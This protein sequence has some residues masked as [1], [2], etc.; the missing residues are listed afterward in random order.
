MANTKRI[1]NYLL[2][3][4]LLSIIFHIL[5]ISEVHQWGDFALYLLQ[6]KSITE[7]SMEG[8][9]AVNT[10]SVNN[11][12]VPTGPNLYPWGFPL[13]LAPVY[14]TF[15]FNIYVFKIYL[16][17]IF[18]LILI[19]M[20]FLFKKKLGDLTSLLLVGIFAFNPL[21]IS[22]NNLI[23][24]DLP[25][26]LFCLLTIL[27]M[28]RTILERHSQ[29]VSY[30]DG[31]LLGFLI[32]FSYFIRSNGIVF[33]PILLVCQLITRYEE[34]E[35]IK[36]LLKID[37]FRLN[38]FFPYIV[39]LSLTIMSNSIFP[40]GSSSH[41]N[42]FD[43]V[44]LGTIMDNVIYYIKLPAV[45]Y[46]G[47]SLS[48]IIYYGTLPFVII[49]MIYNLRRDYL[50]ILFCLASISICIIWPY[51]KG[52]RFIF[53]ILPFYF[54]FLL[55]GMSLIK[56]RYLSSSKIRIDYAFAICLI[57][58]SASVFINRIYKSKSLEIDGPYSSEAKAM[59]HYISSQTPSE[60]IVVFRKPRSMMLFTNR[61]SLR[62][63][64]DEEISGLPNAYIVV[65]KKYCDKDRDFEKFDSKMLE[66]NLLVYR[67]D[68]Y[69]IFKNISI[70]NV[71]ISQG[72]DQ[73][74]FHK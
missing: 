49:G 67:N 24:S 53:P 8:L 29:Q 26:L 6:A 39:F 5:Q 34:K 70:G 40:E 33:L 1:T 25:F 31:F 66:K 47:A 16:V 55:K 28:Q 45:F 37:F 73:K 35:S 52:I 11:S 41:F 56:E 43:M 2:L 9:L 46:P 64:R 57:L 14:Y 48:K 71:S 61:V 7:N 60:A 4:V 20:F 68:R 36:S 30:Q 58:L 21:F 65:D 18:G 13:L 50:Y 19:T 15:G 22:Y 3:I 38:F 62:E 69:E 42:R 72:Q 51:A 17:F 54:Y 23:Q 10:F 32:F 74:K 63:N 44:S 27:C 59:F 12:N